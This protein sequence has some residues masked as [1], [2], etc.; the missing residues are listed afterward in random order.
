MCDSDGAFE[1]ALSLIFYPD[2]RNQLCSC[3]RFNP[4]A[5]NFARMDAFNNGYALKGRRDGMT[6]A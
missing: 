3:I 1:H 6:Q 5:A 4:L 2:F